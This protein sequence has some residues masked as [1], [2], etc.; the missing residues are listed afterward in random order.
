MS[1]QL[2]VLE[3]RAVAKVLLDIMNADGEVS[4]GEGLYF[5][6]LQGQLGISDSEMRL[7][8]EMSVIHCIS[9]IRALLPHEKEIL[10]FMMIEMIKADGKVEDSELELLM[11]ICNMTNIQ[12]P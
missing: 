8:K 5:I 4:V 11:T 6:Q 10:A 3:K 9:I 12:L 2:T 1:L 7:A